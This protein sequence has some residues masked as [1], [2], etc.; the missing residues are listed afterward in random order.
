MKLWVPDVM[1]NAL[2]MYNGNPSLVVG[3]CETLTGLITSRMRTSELRVCE[4]QAWEVRVLPTVLEIIPKHMEETVVMLY[5]VRLVSI[6]IARATFAINLEESP[7]DSLAIAFYLDQAHSRRTCHH[8]DM[9]RIDSQCD[10]RRRESGFLQSN[11][12]GGYP[13]QGD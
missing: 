11:R 8:R 6:S 4:L 1:L 12:R 13:A 7:E 10:S 5:A 3:A 2:S 9:Q